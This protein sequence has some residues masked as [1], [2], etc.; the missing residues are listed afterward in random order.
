[1]PLNMK[2]QI[3]TLA[4]MFAAIRFALSASP[5]LAAKCGGLNKHPCK[6]WERIPSC[7]KGLIEN[8]KGYK[9]TLFN[10]SKKVRKYSKKPQKW[11][12]S[13]KS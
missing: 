1:M 3:S 10:A 4:L 6:V 12:A 7:N 2:K 13:F 8:L 9:R 5:A 11:N